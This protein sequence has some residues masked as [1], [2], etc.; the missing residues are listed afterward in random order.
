MP[1]AINLQASSAVLLQLRRLLD[2]LLQAKVDALYGM[3][4]RPSKKKHH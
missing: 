2:V 4:R 3:H 1:P